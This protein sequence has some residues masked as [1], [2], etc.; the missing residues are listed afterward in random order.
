LRALDAFN[1]FAE[2]QH[3]SLPRIYTDQ[4]GLEE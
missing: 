2:D 1:G 4:R 3:K